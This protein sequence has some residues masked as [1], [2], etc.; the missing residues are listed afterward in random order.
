MF[1]ALRPLAVLLISLASVGCTSWA[2]KPPERGKSPLAPAQM[3][4][5]SIVLEMFFVR[6]PF[7]D[8]QANVDLWAELDEQ[9]FEPHL[10]RCLAENGFRVAISGMQIPMALSQLL[11]L[12]DKPAP[13]DQVNESS[14]LELDSEPRVVRR[15]LQIPTGR[16]AQIVA[17]DV[18]D[19]LPV[20]VCRSGELCGKTYPQAQGL[21]ALRASAE[22]DGRISLS[23]TPELHY[24]QPH[25]RWVGRQGTLRL[26]AGRSRVAYDNLQLQATLAP[27]DMLVL[28][29]LPNRRGSLGHHFFTDRSKGQLQQKVLIVRLA[30]TQHD[31]LF[32]LDAM[33]P[34]VE[35]EGA[36]SS[37]TPASGDSASPRAKPRQSNEAPPPAESRRP[38]ET[39]PPSPTD[40][41]AAAAAHEKAPA[42]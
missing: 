21:F 22:P 34:V 19:S 10:R 4:S 7:G 20:L 35:D 6:V 12:G 29:S 8:E 3:S 5:D 31:D 37:D 13:N 36:A 11:E 1:S 18:Y 17:S 14:L 26:E 28:T 38:A 23:L 15:H 39:A 24:G 30:Q 33:L 2:I 25:Q 42:E 41:A 9:H 32:Q 27:G 16:R 40:R